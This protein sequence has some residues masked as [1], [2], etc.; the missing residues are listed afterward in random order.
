MMPNVRHYVNCAAGASAEHTTAVALPPRPCRISRSDGGRTRLRHLPLSVVVIAEAPPR[1]VSD[2]NEPVPLAAA[3][4]ALGR[5]G[6]AVRANAG[7]RSLRDLAAD[8]GVSHETVRTVLR[9]R[10]AVAR[11]AGLLIPAAPRFPDAHDD[12]AAGPVAGVMVRTRTTSG[13]SPT[14][15]RA[16]AV[17]GRGSARVLRG[18]PS[19]LYVAARAARNRASPKPRHS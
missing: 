13:P 9:E 18:E 17:P 4:L 6:A 2:P 19:R 12:G 1:R 8:F 16:A 7:N 14:L 15:R 10:S 5:A 3:A 11:A